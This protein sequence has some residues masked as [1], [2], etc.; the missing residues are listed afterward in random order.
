M[1]ALR[2]RAVAAALW[3]RVVALAFRS[4]RSPV[5]VARVLARLRRE[6][7]RYRLGGGAR[8]VHHEERW[9]WDLYA[10]GFPS[11]AFDRYVQREL[12]RLLPLDDAIP[13]P[14]TAI[15]AISKRCPMRCE[16][17]CEWDV[18]GRRETLTR[19]DLVHIV[20]DLQD[21]GVAQILLSGGEPLQRFDDVMAILMA[22][23]P[24]T[25]FWLLSSGQGLD[26]DRAADLREVGLTGIALSLDHH[27]APSHDRFRRFRGA[28]AGVEQAAAAAREAG[29]MV[30]LSLCPT[31]A[32]VTAGNLDAYADV[33]RRLG[34][35]FIQIME[36]RAVGHYAGQDV[37]LDPEQE[38]LLEEFTVRGARGGG[39]KVAYPAFTKRR[40]GCD[41][42]GRRYL[43]VDT[44]GE[45]H[46][47]PFCRKPAGNLVSGRLDD[48]L[49]ALCAS[50]CPV[51]PPR[52]PA[53]AP[54]V[55]AV[56]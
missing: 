29:L 41:G 35:A 56:E 11:L 55:V 15:V 3:T 49:G 19:A 10:P 8:Y 36:P 2:D 23:R 54:A 34:A 39:P 53:W 14:Q 52:T 17:C 9:F 31:R 18:L 45:V 50:G 20:A 22:A 43:Y 42:S 27:D 12:E 40:A 30:A 21:R 24:G 51:E 47:C 44:D 32:F 16:H 38:R 4:H 5:R 25:D 28:A 46:P 33:A 7:A 26:A 48:A 1:T 6:A 13:G 37:R